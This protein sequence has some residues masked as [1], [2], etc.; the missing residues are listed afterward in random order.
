MA[1]QLP[2]EF[3]AVDH[4]GFNRVVHD[5]LGGA[6]TI[7]LIAKAAKP[8]VDAPQ[9]K[10]VVLAVELLYH[11]GGGGNIAVGTPAGDEKALPQDLGF[12]LVIPVRRADAD[13]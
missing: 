3:G 7:A 13:R 6:Q 11:L 9:A 12:Y 1:L 2:L 5:L 4:G 10:G 8:H